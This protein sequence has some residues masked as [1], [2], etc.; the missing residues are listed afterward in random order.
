ME[1]LNG[2]LMV[3]MCPD[4]VVV[5]F[6]KVYSS[7]NVN[8]RCTLANPCNSTVHKTGKIMDGQ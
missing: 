2:E 4:L 3:H 8:W 5:T 1:T 6:S 7:P